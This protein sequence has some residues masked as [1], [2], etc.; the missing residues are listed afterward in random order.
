MHNLI[1]THL[2]KMTKHHKVSCSSES[3]GF[4]VAERCNTGCVAPYNLQGRVFEVSSLKCSSSDCDDQSASDLCSSTTMSSCPSISHCE[5]VPKK[6]K[7]KKEK[8]CHKKEK[9]D[10]SWSNLCGSSSSDSDD[11]SSPREKCG[12]SVPIAPCTVVRNRYWDDSCRSDS[13]DSTKCS[14]PKSS[15]DSEDC[16]DKEKMKMKKHH[17]DKKGRNFHI[18]LGPKLGHPWQ[19]RIMGGQCLHVNGIPGKDIH[20]TRGHTYVFQVAVGAEQFFFTEDV[21]GGKMG[22]QS[23]MRTFKAVKLT[24]TTDP[25]ASGT[26]ELV[27]SH[28]LPKIFYYQSAMNNCLG[29]LVFVHDH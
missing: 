17:D 25:L 10:P 13:S 28:D 22:V 4:C 26:Y 3:S 12:I 18:T 9:C 14:S 6:K 23:D 21:Q 1:L 15:S 20:L 27:V 11:C 7:C 8:K 5:K 24:G 2:T 16:D 19:R 29:G